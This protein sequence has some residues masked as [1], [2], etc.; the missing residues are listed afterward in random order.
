MYENIAIPTAIENK[1][2]SLSFIASDFFDKGIVLR[3]K[4]TPSVY[5]QFTIQKMYKKGLVFGKFVP[6][7]KGLNGLFPMFGMP[8]R[9][10]Y[11]GGL[12]LRNDHK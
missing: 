11:R 10:I 4:D 1:I 8:L 9:S 12:F 7:H 6:I 5:L 3:Q 2:M